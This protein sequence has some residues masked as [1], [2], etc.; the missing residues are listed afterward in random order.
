MVHISMG[1]SRASMA[2]LH[3]TL[4]L[5]PRHFGAWSVPSVLYYGAGVTPAAIQSL[6]VAL[7]IN[8]HMRQ[9]KELLGQLCGHLYGPEF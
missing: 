7:R 6:E 5:E 4:Q 3:Q 8:P 2:D 1:N 9:A